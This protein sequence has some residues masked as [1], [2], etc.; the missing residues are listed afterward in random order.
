MADIAAS[1]LARLQN[2]AKET[3]R[4]Y[5]LCLQLFCQEE[6]L[7]KIEKSKYSRNLVLKGGLFVYTLT[8]FESRST[9]D[10]DFLLRKIPNIPE[11]IKKMISEIVDVDTGNGYVS[12]EIGKVETIG[13][14]KQYTGVGIGLV[15]KIKNT[16]TP[17]NIDLS[18]GDVIV[19]GSEKRTIPTQL[20]NF[21]QPTINTYSLESTIAEKIDAIV[22]LMEF[23]SRMKDYYDIYYLAHSFEFDGFTLQKAISKTLQN[24]A[25]VVEKD[26]LKQVV[27]FAD[28]EGMVKKWKAFIK[29]IEMPAIDFSE[30]LQTIDMF[31]SGIFNEIVNNDDFTGKWNNAT[32]QWE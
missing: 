9:V 4:S 15:A 30:V 3:G 32:A 18:V 27:S 29:R 19:P 24:R 8:G 26:S 2:K 21:S 1:V 28:D 13:L 16:R 17:I 10:I 23:T 12:F 25:R 6:F 22:S 11:K 31:L 5:Q 7:R 14:Q 20:D